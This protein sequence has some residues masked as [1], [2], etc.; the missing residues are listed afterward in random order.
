MYYPTINEQRVIIIWI[1]YEITAIAISFI[2]T[3]NHRFDDGWIDGRLFPEGC[4]R[5]EDVWESSFVL[6]DIRWNCCC[7]KSC[8]CKGDRLSKKEVNGA[9]GR[10]VLVRRVSANAMVIIYV[11]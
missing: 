11:W 1:I 2:Q 10:A 4:W 6:E 5:K 3:G 9:P 8:F 7:S